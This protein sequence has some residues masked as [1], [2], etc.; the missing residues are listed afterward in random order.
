MRAADSTDEIVF[1]C[2][3]CG[4]PATTVQVLE[5]GV[6]PPGWHA[7]TPPVDVDH[8]RLMVTT[9]G[10]GAWT[11]QVESDDDPLTPWRKGDLEELRQQD[12]QSTGNYCF[13]CAVWY[14]SRH[15]P[16]EQVVEPGGAPMYDWWWESVCPKGHKR[17]FE[18]W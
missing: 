12:S 18:R 7:D 11:T 13:A 1:S 6:V 5:A 8:R 2:S 17:T 10:T 14:C 3:V 16:I 15:S 4:Q 9:S